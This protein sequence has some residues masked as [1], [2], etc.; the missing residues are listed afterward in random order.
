MDRK[1]Q[2]ES[3]RSIRS[4]GRTLVTKIIIRMDRKLQDE[5]IKS[6]YFVI[7]DRLLWH[8]VV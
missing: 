5:S 1:L 8:D 3:I 7:R 4:I 6:N 2:D